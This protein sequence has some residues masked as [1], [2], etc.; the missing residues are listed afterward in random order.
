DEYAYRLR[1]SAPQPD[2]VLRAVPSSISISS[3]GILTNET[4]KLVKTNSATYTSHVVHVIRKDGFTGPIKLGLRNPPPGFSAQ[5]VALTGTQ[6]MTRISIKCDLV[7]THEDFTLVI[8]GRALINGKEVAHDVVPAE[9]RMQAFLWRHLV[10]A[11]EFKALVF[12][13]SV[14]AEPRRFRK[15]GKK[16]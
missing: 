13:P 2:F 12:D 8:E 11:Q 16:L 3:R 6:T 1:I 9:D 5:S 10:P 4:T 7:R 15:G 14:A